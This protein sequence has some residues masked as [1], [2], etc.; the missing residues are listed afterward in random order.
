MWLGS[1]V[2]VAVVRPAA[3]AP[4]QPLAWESPH[5]T[6]THTNSMQQ[7]HCKQSYYS[8]DSLEVKI[9]NMFIDKGLISIIYKH[10]CKLLRKKW[11]E[12]YT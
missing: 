9:W 11:I 7:I 3:A 10:S 4:I 6:H 12:K 2:A 1:G 5:A 8:H